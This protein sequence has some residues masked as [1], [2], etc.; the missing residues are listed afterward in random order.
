MS[1]EEYIKQVAKMHLRFIRIHPFPDGN[2]RTARAI[3]NMFLAKKGE[4]AVFDKRTKDNY[5]SFIE[6]INNEDVTKYKQAL[7]SDVAT[8]DQIEDKVV[9]KL[10]EYL[11]IELLGERDLY[12][13]RDITEPLPIRKEADDKEK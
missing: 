13:D 7:S 5:G 3:T 12:K 11:G 1:K 9:Y 6:M 4:C 10:E 8:C 2:G